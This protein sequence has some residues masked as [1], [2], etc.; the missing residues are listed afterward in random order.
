MRDGLRG[1]GEFGLIRALTADLKSGGNV[2]HGIGDDCAVV[3]FGGKSML[4]TCDAS[5]EGVH[6]KRDWGVP[7][8]L[9]WKAAVSALSDIAAMGGRANFVMVTLALPEELELA[10][11]EA[12]YRGIR[13]A[14]E[15]AGAIIVGGDTSASHSGI[16]MDLT[17]VGEVVGRPMLRSG[18]QPGDVIAMSGA[19]GERS[20]GLH[21]LLHDVE[22][23]ELIREY[24]HPL[25]RLAEGQW[26]QAQ[27]GVKAMMDV[28]DGLLPDARHIA[29]SSGVGI[30][31]WTDWLPASARLEEFWRGQGLDCGAQRLRSG[32]EYELLVV[33]DSVEAGAICEAFEKKFELPLTVIGECDDGHEGVRV[34]GEESDEKG[35]EHFL[36]P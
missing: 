13:D 7:E 22:A 24:L 2:Q 30:D 28:S 31:L 5:L 6:F 14:V 3:A 19:I 1:L 9:G 10:F 33:L 21:A 8:D 36:T 16:V 35:Y 15:S 20:A 25:P 34:D 29:E 17:V 18:A 32:E 12:L 4:L 11:V 27:P 23:P 26:L